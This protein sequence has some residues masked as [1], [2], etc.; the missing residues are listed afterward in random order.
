MRISRCLFLVVALA[1]IS[2]GNE[3]SRNTTPRKVKYESAVLVDESVEQSSFAGKVVAASDLSLGFRV[4]GIINNMPIADGEFVRKGEVVARLDSRDYKLQLSATQ[5]E[6][7]AIKAEADRVI[8]LYN[9]QSISANTYDKATNGLRAITAKLEAHRNALADCELRAPIDGYIVKS[10]FG[11]GEAVAAGTPVVSMIS[12]AAPQITID[13]PVQN[14]IKSS[15][16]ESAT[17][18]FEL[19]DGDQ[20]CLKLIGISPKGNLNQ[21]YRATFEI[22]PNENGV[23]PAVGMSAIVDI[24]YKNDK[25][26]TV[27]IPFSAVVE[28]DGDSSVWVVVDNRVSS[29]SV[30]IEQI[31]HSG[32]CTVVS[33]IDAGEVVVVAGVHSLK[34]GQ[35]VSL[36]EEPSAS[37]V[38]KIK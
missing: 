9:D 33:G 34:E 1:T 12:S 2:C 31:L 6:Y 14:Y 36:L 4:A 22:E 7:D 17:A 20:F 16:F 5:A 29:R 24:N 28:S 18:F 11:R 21:L 25:T 10:N 30:K 13:I 32:R 19:Y 23:L 37:N 26:E 35:E 38:G 8:E 27:D 3:S 15:S